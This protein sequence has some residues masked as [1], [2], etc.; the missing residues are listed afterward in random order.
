MDDLKQSV[1]ALTTQNDQDLLM[2]L[3]KFQALLNKEPDLSAIDKTYDGKAKTV[4]ISHIEMTLDE[5][6]FG[7]WST[8]NF[9]WS[10]IANEVQG[11]LELVLVHPISGREIR[12]TGAASIV[13]TVDEVPESVKKNPQEKNRWALNTDNKKPNA[14]DLAHP[15]LKAEC[16]KNAAQSLGKLF[17]RDLNRKPQNVDQ[18]KPLIKGDLLPALPQE[19]MQKECSY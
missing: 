1:I 12:R 13:I 17:G 6:F 5:V 11:S 4:T 2:K 19:L 15:K 9:K 18:Y 14:M 8:V 10:G 3:Q 7:Q 16:T